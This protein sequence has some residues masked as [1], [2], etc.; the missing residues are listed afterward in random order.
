MKFSSLCDRQWKKI[1]SNV[2]EFKLQDVKRFEGLKELTTDVEDT[3]QV[4]S[5]GQRWCVFLRIF[6]YGSQLPC[7]IDIS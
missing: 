7:A 2:I 5:F 3:E 1:K 4:E 6:M